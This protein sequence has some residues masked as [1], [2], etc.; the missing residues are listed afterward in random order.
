MAVFVSPGVYT[1]EIDL[2]LYIPNLSTTAVGM[3]G[4]ASKG[5]I[6]EPT[7]IT[8]VIQFI[9][10]F[11]NP[12]DPDVEFQPGVYAALQ[13]LQQGR[14]LWYVRVAEPDPAPEVGDASNYLAK[15]A[16]L[17]LYQDATPATI[18]GT[19]NS[20]ITL[21][22]SNNTL[23]FYVDGISPG[24][25]VTFSLG[26]ATSL[27]KSIRDIIALLNANTTF[28]TYFTASISVS[29]SLTIKRNL[30]GSS[31]SLRISGTGVSASNIFGFP[32][33]S[34][35][36]T[37]AIYGTGV[38]DEQPWI[39]GN[40]VTFPVTIV[41]DTNDTLDFWVSTAPAVIAAGTSYQIPAGAYATVTALVDAINAISGFP[42]NYVASEYGSTT[43]SG[44]LK[45]TLKTASAY[46]NFGIDGSISTSAV[47][48]IFGSINEQKRVVSNST[49][50]PQVITSA[51]N[52][53]TLI[54]ENAAGVQTSTT[55]TIPSASYAAATDVSTALN[56]ITA[57][58]ALFTSSVVSSRLVITVDGTGTGV[59]VDPTGTA[60]TTIL[61]YSAVQKRKET[62]SAAALS[63]SA[64][65]QG[66]WGNNLGIKTKINY[67]NGVATSFNLDV[68]ESNILRESFKNLVKTP[69]Q[70][71][72][73]DRP[74][75]MIDNPAYVET[76]I[77]G[78]SSFIT[79][80]NPVDADE[81]L[82]LDFP[83][84]SG[85]SNPSLLSGGSNGAPP[86]SASDPS[87]YIGID[88]GTEK[89]GL[90]FFRNPENYDINLLLAPGI[91][92]AP[93][94]AELISICVS[95]ADCMT[96]VDT[97]YDLRPQ[98]VIDWVNGQGDYADDH[99]A[100]NSSYAAVYWPWLQV[101]DSV[102]AKK[103]W[104]PPCGHVSQVYAFTDNN[105]EI[106]SAPAGLTRGRLYSALKA[107]YVPTQGERDVLYLANVN[108]IATFVRD[109]IN[110]YGQKT[111]QRKPTALD[112][113]NVRRLMLYLRKVVATAVN[114]VT[115]EPSDETTWVQITNLIEPY[116]Q[117]IKDRRGL[118][119]FQVRCDSTTNTP[120]VIDRNEMRVIILLK[121]SRSA[122]YISIDFVLTPTGVSLSEL[123]F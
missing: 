64:T 28:A 17:D 33:V 30:S 84:D 23:I 104:T 4:L 41:E 118:T 45:I 56:L 96:I 99:A 112:R 115:F 25:T 76:A 8:N 60:N 110:V 11:G 121:P 73:E 9:S 103:V 88:T 63:V 75:T 22:S 13:Y 92:D 10:T 34:G 105:A 66:T 32:G 50:F 61:G 57:F 47:T 113:V 119:E 5:P 91:A 109:G 86:S 58:A 44:Q 1:R 108:C 48:T 107:E 111:L 94:I 67:T 68:Y 70:I 120:D 93:V 37:L 101:Y 21:T 106:W 24:F 52:T 79:V 95:R 2:S 74:G 43:G 31:H 117:T 71:E 6:N 102:N 42:T 69:L 19:V 35:S 14:Q 20:L 16:T 62:T 98:E 29:G 38:I 100:F 39:A 123:V 27:V 72:D 80:V 55:F 82:S 97:P 46:T 122:E 36:T 65:T 51:N 40:S 78:V 87:L 116:L 49:T 3:V 59:I 12:S 7:L 81:V 26:S 90:Q 18:T 114:Y 54:S 15:Y 77:N 83:L 89:T 85:L 53:L